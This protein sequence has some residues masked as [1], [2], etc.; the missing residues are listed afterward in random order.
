MVGRTIKKERKNLFRSL[1]PLLAI[2]IIVIN[3]DGFGW[4]NVR[5]DGRR[6]GDLEPANERGSD[7]H[8]IRVELTGYAT[9]GFAAAE[10]EWKQ[11]NEG[12]QHM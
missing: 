1:F 11:K 9:P 10:P 3:I 2:I 5:T 12:C 4:S 7:C 6:E 8:Q